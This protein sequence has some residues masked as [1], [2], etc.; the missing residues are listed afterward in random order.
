VDPWA[1]VRFFWRQNELVVFD[2]SNVGRQLE[3][4]ADVLFPGGNRLDIWL[5]RNSAPPRLHRSGVRGGDAVRC[6]RKALEADPNN[7]EALN[8]LA[9]ILTTAKDPSLRDGADAVQLAAKAV[10]LTQSR[11]PIMI[12][13]MA[14]AM[15]EYGDFSHAATTAEVARELAQLT[16]RT[17]IAEKNAQAEDLYAGRKTFDGH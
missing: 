2:R 15:A 16:G 14:A 10:T 12:G 8:N 7:T 11:E 17:E 6:Y 13:T 4:A 5:E 9:W 3:S 1:S